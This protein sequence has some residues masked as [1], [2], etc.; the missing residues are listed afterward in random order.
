MKIELS[1]TSYL[2]PN[3]KSWEL[4]EKLSNINF[5]DYGNF[6]SDKKT[7]STAELVVF[8]LPDLIDYFN[9]NSNEKLEIIKIKNILILV[10]KKL[11]KSNKSIIISVSE[12]LYHNTINFSQKN[13]KTKKYKFFFIEELI[14]L[15][16]KYKNLY[17]L[18]LEEIF[19]PIGFDNCFDQRN[20]YL[21]RCRLSTLGIEIL[22]DNLKKILNRIKYTNKKVLLLDCDNTLWGGV[23]AEDGLEKIQIKNDGLG[24]AYYEFQKAIKK[25][26]DSG[27]LIALVSKNN[28]NDVENVFNNHDSMYLKSEDITCSKVNWV[29][30]SKNIIEIAKELNLDLNSFVYWDDNPIERD[31]VRINLK[32]VT[33]FEPDEDV[34][35]WPLQLLEYEGFSKFETTK[36]DKLKSKQYK[37]RSRFI[38]DKTNN[39][40][41][42]TYLKSINIKP[43]KIKI[44]NSSIS[45]AVQMCQKTNQFNLRTIR[46]NASE[47][48]KTAKKNDCFLVNLQDIYGDHGLVSLV[49]LKKIDDKHMFIDN[50]LMSCRIIGR[51]LESWIL[52][53]IVRISSKQ[54]I[55]Y[56]L[57]EYIPTPKNQVVKDF[58]I[59][60][61]FKKVK[62]EELK[63]NNKNL[64]KF[65]LNK[66][67][68][69]YIFKTNTKIPYV[70][71]IYENN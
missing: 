56:L 29:D 63:K 54:K 60:H 5:N 7:S 45:R 34:A 62:K 51:H 59:S 64:C 68:E 57:A 19:S 40:N 42:I 38:D 66:K 17:I 55:K 65:F 35:K 4:L 53:E 3:N 36:S 58:L 8:F 16:K 23:V 37:Q 41:E 13:K 49:S 2:L 47:L 24:L 46:S 50:F 9:S 12:F 25:I 10:E 11:K 33:V 15:T 67:S 18:D 21:C 39:K 30:K 71:E 26:K 48:K 27:I 31:K 44:N 69:Y 6:L 20:Y 28:K 32:D 1:S 70:K 61:K 22:A 43:K 14:K 52:A